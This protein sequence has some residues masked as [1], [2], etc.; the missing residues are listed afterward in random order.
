MPLLARKLSTSTGDDLADALLAAELGEPGD[1]GALGGAVFDELFASMSEL[2]VS[3]P[4]ATLRLLGRLAS[5]ERADVRARAA[6]ALGWFVDH[7]ARRVEEL[8]LPLAC[9]ASRKVRAAA[10][11]A[12]ADLIPVA[13]DPWKLMEDWQA[14]PDR[15]REVLQAA[16]RSLPPPLGD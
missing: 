7:Y 9:D 1:T 12:L 10:A 13:A 15:A 4:Y 16:R 11:E 2:R 8:L 6:R 5:D 14:H 3:V